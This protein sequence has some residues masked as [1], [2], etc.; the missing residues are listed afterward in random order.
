M[1]ET[2]LNSEQFLTLANEILKNNQRIRF[3]AHGS[4]M[5]PC[6]RDNDLIEIKPIGTDSLGKGDVVL[7][8]PLPGRF[9]VHRIIYVDKENHL[10]LIQGDALRQPDGL[11]PAS[12]ILGSVSALER[13]GKW[14]RLDTPTARLIA[15]S[16]VWIF[17]LIRWVFTHVPFIREFIRDRNEQ[18]GD[19]L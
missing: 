12:M 19:L 1:N 6:I 16:L 3:R 10:F 13:R 7:F 14:Y 11:I 5:R 17:P 8:N 2:H 9:L 18:P 4:S 15:K